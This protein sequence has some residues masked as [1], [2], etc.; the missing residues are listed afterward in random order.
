V[1]LARIEDRTQLQHELPPG[2]G[3]GLELRDER[4][5]PSDGSGPDGVLGDVAEPIRI[6]FERLEQRPERRVVGGRGSGRAT[7]RNQLLVGEPLARPED[8]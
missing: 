2:C 8:A 7:A 1:R 4:A 5:R 3:V 6:F